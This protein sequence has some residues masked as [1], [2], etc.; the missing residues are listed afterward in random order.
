MLNEKL[1]IRNKLNYLEEL[2]KKHRKEVGVARDTGIYLEDS[3]VEMAQEM[4]RMW[5]RL[6]VFYDALLDVRN[7]AIEGFEES[8][9]QDTY[10]VI[11]DMAQEALDKVVENG[12]LREE[13]K[14][15][16]E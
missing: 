13:V 6:N 1:Q 2:T 9:G 3:A 10:R 7:K 5:A 16:K 15:D 8:G 12:K 4:K 14:N 11:Y